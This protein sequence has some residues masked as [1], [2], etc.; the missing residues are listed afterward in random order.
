MDSLDREVLEQ[1]STWLKAG[2][3]VWLV[4]VVETWGSAPRPPGALLVMRDDGLVEVSRP[5]GHTWLV[6]VEERG[7]WP[8][9]PASCGKDAVPVTDWDISVIR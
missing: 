4:T 2:R 9:L 7:N 8:D 3:G 6:Q 5:G 1:A